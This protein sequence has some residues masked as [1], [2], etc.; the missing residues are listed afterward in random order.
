MKKQDIY[1]YD[2]ELLEGEKSFTNRTIGAPEQL[3]RDLKDPGSA[4]SQRYNPFGLSDEESQAIADKYAADSDKYL[5]QRAVQVRRSAVRADQIAAIDELARRSRGVGPS[6][7][8]FQVA[9][10]LD[11]AAGH[12]LSGGGNA[13]VQRNAGLAGSTIGATGIMSGVNTMNKEMTGAAAGFDQSSDTASSQDVAMAKR[14]GLLNLAQYG[15]NFEEFNNVRDMEMRWKELIQRGDYQK[16]AAVSQLYKNQIAQ[17]RNRYNELLAQ[18]RLREAEQLGIAGG[19]MSAV[20]SAFGPFGVPLTA[21][22]AGMSAKGAAT[23]ADTT[24]YRR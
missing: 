17:N 19:V 18:G 22:G 15:Q 7:A 4:Q 3:R 14:Q 11:R 20:G 2:K 6:M 23:A 24:G 5:N 10:G 1:Q 21:A 16:A 12:A 9:R 8:G 13:L